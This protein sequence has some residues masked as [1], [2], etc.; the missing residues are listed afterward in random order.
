MSLSN[1]HHKHKPKH[2]HTNQNRHFSERWPVVFWSCFSAMKHPVV[3]RNHYPWWQQHVLLSA[4]HTRGHTRAHTHTG[5]IDLPLCEK[6]NLS[7]THIDINTM[8]RDVFIPACQINT[9]FSITNTLKDAFISAVATTDTSHSDRIRE[10]RGETGQQEAFKFQFTV[11]HLMSLPLIHRFTDGSFQS[12]RGLLEQFH[13]FPIYMW[14][15]VYF[16][17]VWIF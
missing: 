15:I 4:R 9:I 16:I 7:K 10:P 12:F 3:F 1:E 6:C 5:Y 17:S 2:T 8:Q 11:G 14:Y 13:I